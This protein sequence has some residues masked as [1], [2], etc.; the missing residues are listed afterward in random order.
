MD[1]AQYWSTPAI[2][3]RPTDAPMHILV[4]TGFD[5]P[6][7][8]E[9]KREKWVEIQA[10]SQTE[11]HSRIDIHPYFSLG[12]FSRAG[13]LLATVFLKR[14]A[15]GFHHRVQIWSECPMVPSPKQ[16]SCLFGAGLNRSSRASANHLRFAGPMRSSATGTTSSLDPPLRIYAA[17]TRLG[18]RFQGCPHSCHGGLQLNLQ[19]RQYHTRLRKNHHYET[20]PCPL[21]AFIRLRLLLGLTAPLGDFGSLWRTLPFSANRASRLLYGS[22]KPAARQIVLES[23]NLFSC[24]A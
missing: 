3:F 23:I 12:A 8:V 2:G 7:I 13:A 24:L 6:A 20:G 11:L 22:L 21:S 14:V 9:L 17:I 16:S 15:D 10:A 1:Y 4:L 19:L 18:K 5:P